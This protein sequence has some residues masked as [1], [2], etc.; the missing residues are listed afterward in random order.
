MWKD[1]IHQQTSSDS[2]FEGFEFTSCNAAAFFSPL[3][4]RNAWGCGM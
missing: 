1:R 3:Q 2:E 4:E